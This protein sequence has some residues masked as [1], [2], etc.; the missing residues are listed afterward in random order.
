MPHRGLCRSGTCPAGPA[1]VSAGADGRQGT[2]ATTVCSPA[3]VI[4]SRVMNA[5]A[6]MGVMQIIRNSYVHSISRG[7]SGTDC[8]R[9]AKEG[10]GF[11]FKGW[12]P[13]WTRLQPT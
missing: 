8:P 7:D 9:L 6:N 3:D 4:K 5:P 10:P 12:L 2:V 13:S 1:S 11:M